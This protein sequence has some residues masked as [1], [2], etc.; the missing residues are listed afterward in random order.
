M[1]VDHI[2]KSNNQPCFFDVEKTFSPTPLSH[3][4][5]KLWNNKAKLAGNS[6]FGGHIE[7]CTLPGTY[8]HVSGI[9]AFP[10]LFEI[11]WNNFLTEVTSE[12]HHCA[13]V[14]ING[15]PD[16]CP[17]QR[18][19]TIFP[20]TWLY[21]HRIHTHNLGLYGCSPSDMSAKLISRSVHPSF[22]CGK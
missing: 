17:R 9:Q 16:C 15:L 8:N 11:P 21:V 4:R 3:D 22:L 18:Q 2:F 14:T 19:E 5:I 13:S 20:V 1:F 6:V 10:I 12:I 7:N